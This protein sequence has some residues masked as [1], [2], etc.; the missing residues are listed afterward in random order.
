MSA[1]PIPFQDEFMK[2]TEQF[3]E[4]LDVEGAYREHIANSIASDFGH[5]LILVNNVRVVRTEKP[6]R[7]YE[8]YF[9]SPQLVV[10]ALRQYLVDKEDVEH[11]LVVICD[12]SNYAIYIH[13]VSQG[14]VN[15][16]LV[17]ARCIFR[18]A[19][20]LNAVSIIIAHTHPS[21][22]VEPSQADMQ[23]TKRLVDAGKLLD[24]KVLDH[25]ILNTYSGAYKSFCAS[26]LL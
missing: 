26:G 18:A 20:I 4:P 10:N 14:T 9:D 1:E 16:A 13:H 12:Q 25:I 21:G 5:A 6:V 22:N 19:M 17:D 8:T 7:L 24:V 15:Q 2:W 23:L 11:M 3:D